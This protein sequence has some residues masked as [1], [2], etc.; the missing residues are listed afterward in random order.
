MGKIFWHLMATVAVTTSL[1]VT[2]F[3]AYNDSP[4][5]DEPPHLSAGYTY[6]NYNDYKLNPEHPPILKILAAWPLIITGA[7]L[8]SQSRNGQ[9]PDQWQLGNDLIY[10]SGNNPDQL[11]FLARLPF[12]LIFIS[13][14]LI[15][16]FALKKLYDYKVA[17][18]TVFLFSLSPTI[19]GH[20]HLVTTDWGA[21]AFIF[22]SILVFS[23]F[24]KS[25]SNNKAILV[26][27]LLGLALIT[28][29][30]ALILIPVFI[31][32]TIIYIL[33]NHRKALGLYG[34]YLSGFLIIIMM[35]LAIIGTAYNHPNASYLVGLNFI[36]DRLANGSVTFL[37]GNI[38]NQ[39]FWYYF[40]FLFIVKETLGFLI[41]LILAIAYPLTKIKN[42]SLS[43]TR[44]W[45]RNNTFELFLIIF[46][47]TYSLIA[48]TSNLN[49]GYRHLIPILPGLYFLTA[50]SIINW[51]KNHPM[52]VKNFTITLLMIGIFT[53]YLLA[54]PAYIGYFNESIGGT[55]NAYR[56]AVDS[57]LDWG[58][59]LKRLNRYL[60]QN[61]IKKIKLDYFGGG[62]PGYYLGNRYQD[63]SVNDG[64]A[65]GWIAV[66]ATYLQNS[67][68]FYLH[69]GEKDYDWLRNR[70]VVANINGSILIYKID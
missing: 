49:I 9:E 35:G 13:F 15:L 63:W 40:P 50:R 18:L 46:I 31:F 41:L 25:P 52:F 64:P 33:A 24:I 34:N 30:S 37:L 36:S 55:K 1:I 59:D 53:S 65:S 19:T 21:T 26:G 68:W 28:K 47:A 14:G 51:T 48:L 61:D 66:S 7:K 4:V 20:N 45:V 67:H 69:N 29:F 16:F 3:L 56:L 70:K 42:L 58:Q 5:V 12:I 23:L 6:L 57:N 39:S 32:G 8:H 62:E 43:L 27:T 38:T 10:K 44:D 60:E 11:M 54:Y 22:L 17:S 2:I